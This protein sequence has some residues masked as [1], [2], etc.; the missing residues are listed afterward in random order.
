MERNDG[1]VLENRVFNALSVQRLF[2]I[3]DLVGTYS[4]FHVY[5]CMHDNVAV[6]QSY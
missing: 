2:L 4:P 1:M 5:V 6:S 3:R